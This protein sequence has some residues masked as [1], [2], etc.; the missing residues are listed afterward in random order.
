MGEGGDREQ[1]SGRGIFGI[2][3]WLWRWI[4]AKSAGFAWQARRRTPPMHAAKLT[5]H[6]I[7]YLR[8]IPIITR[9]RHWGLELKSCPSGSGAGKL[10]AEWL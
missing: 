4:R 1:G 8:T 2:G 9:Q 3:R 10:G 6:R 7:A 5:G